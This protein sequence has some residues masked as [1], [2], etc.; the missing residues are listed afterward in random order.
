MS[1]TL[2]RQNSRDLILLA[3]QAQS[4]R[5]NVELNAICFRFGARIEELRKRGY[6][7]RT[8]E[9]RGGVVTYSYHGVKPLQ[10][11]ELWA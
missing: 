9:K 10:Q 8:G 3:F 11:P 2:R 6:D 1:E 7:I 5:T 4:V